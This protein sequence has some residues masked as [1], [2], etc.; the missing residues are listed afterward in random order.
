LQEGEAAHYDYFTNT[1][2]ISRSAAF[3]NDSGL[4]NVVA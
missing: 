4:T 2:K 3:R 1:V